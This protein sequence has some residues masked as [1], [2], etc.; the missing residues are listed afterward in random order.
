VDQHTLRQPKGAKQ[1]RKRIGRGPA[2]GQ[3]TYAG[4]GI[5]GQK[6]RGKVRPGFEGGQMPL[7]RR[8]PRLRGFKNPSRV[9]FQAINLDTLADRFEAGATV[10]AAA[11]F[12]QRLLDSPEQPFKV[13]C[14]G[15][16]PHALNVTAPRLSEAA[17]QAINSAGGTYEETAPVDRTP[18]NRIHRRRAAAGQQAPPARQ[19]AAAAATQ[20]ESSEPATETEQPEEAEQA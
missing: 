19:P 17:K 7:V 3:G 14:R 10:D 4:R 13:L 6:T 1:A 12:N 8:V 20:P 5:K 15:E 2:S 16:L 18:R 11:L 9:E